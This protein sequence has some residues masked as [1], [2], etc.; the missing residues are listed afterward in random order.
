MPLALPQWYF[1]GY[2]EAFFFFFCLVLLELRRWSKSNDKPWTSFSCRDPGPQSKIWA[3]VYSATGLFRV[4]PVP[5]LCLTIPNLR[6][7]LFTNTLRSHSRVHDFCAFRAVTHSRVVR[8]SV[9]ARSAR[10]PDRP[11]GPLSQKGYEAMQPVPARLLSAQP[12]L[13]E[14]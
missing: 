7:G 2:C 4:S 12:H 11:L 1:G 13:T 8:S 5:T 14:R 10:R 6:L 9:T 3:G